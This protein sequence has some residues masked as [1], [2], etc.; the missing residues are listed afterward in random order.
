MS[1][2]LS[3]SWDERWESI[4]HGCGKCCYEKH[5]LHNGTLIIDYDKP[6]KFLDTESKRCNVYVNRFNACKKCQKITLWT[7][8]FSPA[9]PPD[10]G[11]V[12]KIRGPFK[13]PLRWLR[14]HLKI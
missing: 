13:H 1:T 3:K 10:C 6:C 14:S 11:Y 5:F 12:Q 8:L 2:K 7:A 4:C 9:L